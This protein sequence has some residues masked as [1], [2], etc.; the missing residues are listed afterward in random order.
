[1]LALKGQM[2]TRV[3]YVEDPK[4]ALPVQ[5]ENGMQNWFEARVDEDPLQV[6]DL[7][8]RPVAIL[9]LGARLPD[10]QS[11]PDAQ[12]LYG[13]PP[14]QQCPEFVEAPTAET[15]G[16]EPIPAPVE[17]E[18]TRTILQPATPLVVEPASLPGSADEHTDYFREGHR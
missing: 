6:A 16:Q 3:I 10:S 5:E 12:F 4:R 8:G 17:P 13:C 7:L 18:T 1:M 11:G 15:D 14:W 9:R 2:V